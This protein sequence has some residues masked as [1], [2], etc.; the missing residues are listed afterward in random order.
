[1]RFIQHPIGS[2]DLPR[3]YGRSEQWIGSPVSRNA[4]LPSNLYLSI[5]QCHVICCTRNGRRSTKSRTSSFPS[6]HYVPYPY[7]H[8][9]PSS[10]PQFITIFVQSLI[11]LFL[12]CHLSDLATRTRPLNWQNLDSKHGLAP[13]LSSQMIGITFGNPGT[14]LSTT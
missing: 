8:C 2:E 14:V 5:L 4:R 7:I 1:M 13:R 6:A 3:T 12:V 10:C 9:L 11:L